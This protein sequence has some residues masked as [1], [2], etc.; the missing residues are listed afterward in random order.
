MS[1]SCLIVQLKAV[2]SSA[3]AS[4][5]LNGSSSRHGATGREGGME[6]YSVLQWS[7]Q[8]SGTGAPFII[9]PWL[10]VAIDDALVSRLAAADADKVWNA[11]S[12]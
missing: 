9:E 3:T 2:A 10:K 4:Q 5:A 7:M 1:V 11:C 8:Q 12:D 6:G